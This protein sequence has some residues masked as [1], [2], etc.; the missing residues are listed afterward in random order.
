MYEFQINEQI[1]DFPQNTTSQAL[2]KKSASSRKRPPSRRPNHHGPCTYQKTPVDSST[3]EEYFQVYKFFPLIP[4]F[5]DT[6]KV[7]W[8]EGKGGGEKV[9]I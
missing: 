6:M 2:C 7:K 3:R 9:F 4:A 1:S 8:P 5:G